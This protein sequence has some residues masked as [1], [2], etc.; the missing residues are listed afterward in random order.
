[1][2]IDQ[3]KILDKLYPKLRQ[4]LE[5]HGINT[6]DKF[7]CISRNHEDLDPSCHIMHHNPNLAYCF[8]CSRS[9]NIFHAANELDGLPFRGSDFWKFTIPELCERFGI[10]YTPVEL[11]EEDKERLKMFAAYRDASDIICTYPDPGKFNGYDTPIYEHIAERGWNIETAK[12][13]RI[14][15]VPSKEVFLNKMKE[16][17]W[18]EIYLASIG[19]TDTR[20]FNRNSLI[21][22]VCDENGR[23]RGFAARDMK[24]N[25]KNGDKYVNSKTTLIYHKNELLF[26]YHNARQHMRT[27]EPIWIVEGYADVPTLYEAGI[28]NVA[29]VGGTSFGEEHIELL[30]RCDVFNLIFMFDNDSYEGTKKRGGQEALERILNNYFKG[31][32]IF[33]IKIKPLPDNTDPDEFIREYGIEEFEKL[34]LLIP[35]EWI[36]KRAPYDVDP[37]DLANKLIPDIAIEPTAITREKM[38]KALKEVTGISE[39]TIKDDVR[40]E[41]KKHDKDADR[42]TKQWA[43]QATYKLREI[44]RKHATPDEV[45][46]HLGTTWDETKRRYEHIE[47]DEMKYTKRLKET[48]KKFMTDS[49][50]PF[51]MGKFQRWATLTKT[52]RRTGSFIGLAAPANIGKSSLIRNISWEIVT[53]NNDALLIYFSLD[54]SFD[55][56]L[57]SFLAIETHMPI[58]TIRDAS[59][60]LIDDREKMKR[61]TKA[62]EKL[63]LLKERLILKDISDGSTLTYV[64]KMIKYY[65]QQHPNLNPIIVIDSFN[66]LKDFLNHEKEERAG[67]LSTKLSSIATRYDVP[68]ITVLELRKT[69]NARATLMDIK[70]TRTIEYDADMV[71]MMHQD[72]HF[73]QDSHWYWWCET[74]IGR[75]KMP[76][77]ELLFAKNKESEFKGRIF[78]KFRSDQSTFEELSSAEIKE[79]ID[80]DSERNRRQDFI[81]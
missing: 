32:A 5:S 48:R 7:C 49:Q 47:N 39:E 10:E 27:D 64:E 50:P 61:W 60:E 34:P 11:T 63:E 77:C 81:R 36:L 54:D 8:G 24:H 18:D 22:V 1:M 35:F 16:S 3:Q 33:N 14:G 2:H 56:L 79:F 23:P 51:D 67:L 19:L 70:N 58:N 69:L 52:I 72:L 76:I 12:Q 65:K 43:E 15:A 9:F 78:F 42:A 40:V 4:Y 26:N 31:S 57:S 75:V 20:I 41:L 59:R 80:K 29:G 37:Y 45:L 53:N 17:E 25:G 66:K 30:S 74:E 21:F 46:D 71:L 68:I 13:L 6:E 28:K 44:M 73:D 55:K 38:I 62:W